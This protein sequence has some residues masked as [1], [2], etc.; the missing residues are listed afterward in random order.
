MAYIGNSPEVN[1]FRIGVEKFNGTGACT[2]FTIVRDIDE[3]KDIEVIVDG[4]QQTPDDS[5]GVTNG[6]ITFTEPP[7]PGSN[8]ITVTYRAPIVFTYN[9]VSSSQI[10]AGAVTETALAT[11]SITTSK[12]ADDS[13]TTTKVANNSITGEKISTPADIFDDAFLFGGM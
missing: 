3:A 12:V 6:V 9:Q 10:L 8:N 4:V 2:Q 1:S 7:S 11:N 13:I 5:Y